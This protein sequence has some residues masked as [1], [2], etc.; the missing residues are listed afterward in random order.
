MGVMFTNLAFTNWGPTLYWILCFSSTCSSQNSGRTPSTHPSFTHPVWQV[1][2]L[3]VNLSKYP[4]KVSPYISRYMEIYGSTRFHIKSN[5]S[6]SIIPEFS[7]RESR[8][9]SMFQSQQLQLYYM[10]SYPTHQST[11]SQ[12]HLFDSDLDAN[13]FSM[14]NHSL[15]E[16]WCWNLYTP[17]PFLGF[18]LW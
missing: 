18:T 13:K 17:G 15:C 16:A 6:R 9:F 1:Q 2:T 8:I 5:T 14:S 11:I 12:L 3:F 4:N 7:D 10:Y